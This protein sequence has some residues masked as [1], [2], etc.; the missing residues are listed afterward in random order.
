MHKQKLTLLWTKNRMPQIL[1]SV[2]TLVQC[3]E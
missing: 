1:N 3:T 2:N